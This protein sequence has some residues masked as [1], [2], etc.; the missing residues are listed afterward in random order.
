[1]NTKKFVSVVTAASL[2]ALSFSGCSLLGG[3]DKAAIEETATSYIEYIMSGKLNKSATLVV[4]EEDYF[5]ENAFPVQQ[6]DLLNVVFENTEFEVENVEV[7]K[8]SGSAEI[9]FSIPDLDSIADEGYSFTEFLDAVGDIDDKVE[10]TVELDFSKD[11]DEWL[12]EGDSTEDLFNFFGGIGADLEFGLSEG[13]AIEAV[14]TFVNYLAQGDVDGVLSMSPDGAQIFDSVGE[15]IDNLGDTTIMGN[16]FSSY[17]SRLEYTPSIV[18]AN[19]DEVVV[20]LEGTAPAAAAAVETAL[21]DP[22]V[23]VPIMADYLESS[24]NGTYEFTQ[25]GASILNAIYTAVD[26]TSATEAYIATVTVT[27]DDEGNFYCDP[28]DGFFYD[29]E[30][31]DISDS[32]DLVVDALD[33]LLEQGRISQSDYNLYMASY[34]GGNNGDYDVTDISITEGDD[35]YDYEYTI[36]DDM[37]F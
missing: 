16:I 27:A 15:I 30:F 21:Q 37:I 13:S 19:E 12:I 7:N 22:D 14:D 29:F 35:L 1:M 20:A 10:E 4:D 2:F 17:Y 32:G 26:N 23:L 28:D 8:D 9:V 24:I 33:L 5:Q 36:T 11:G 34:G 18:S 31:P 6:E 3:K 25:T